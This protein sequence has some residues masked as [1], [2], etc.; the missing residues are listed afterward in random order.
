MHVKVWLGGEGASEIGSRDIGGERKGAIEALLLRLEPTG[1]KVEGGTVWHR[2]PK[3]KA[4]AG[5]EIGENHGDIRNV[6]GL[7]LQAWEKACEVVAFSRDVDADDERAEAV[8]LG[9]EKAEMTYPAVAIIGGVAKPAIEGWILAL[10]GE[11]NTDEMSRLRTLERMKNRS[12]EEKNADAYVA[13]IEA[14]SLDS[15]PRGCDSL[16]RWLEVARK[17][18]GVAVHG[19][20]PSL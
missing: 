2:I 1:W 11:A 13:I 10:L 17:K 5:I 14:A 4:R 12:V 15:V 16:I 19:S 18:L 20:S 7:V 9:I 8:R 3:Y 6:M